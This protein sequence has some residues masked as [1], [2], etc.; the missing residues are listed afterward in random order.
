[1]VARKH[2]KKILKWLSLLT[3]VAQFANSNSSISEFRRL[4]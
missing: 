4:S 2:M 1:M 3:Q